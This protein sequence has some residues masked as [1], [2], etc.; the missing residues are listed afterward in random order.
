MKNDFSAH[1]RARVMLFLVSQCITLFGSTLVQMAVVWYATMNT[2]SGSWVAAFSVAAYLPQF[3]ISFLGG[4]WADR[5]DRKLLII[6]SDA[7]IAVVTLVMLLIMPSVGDEVQLMVSLLAMSVLRSMGSGIQTPAVNS[8]I[9]LL[10]PKDQLMRY[11]GI[12]SAMQSLVQ[13]A[14]PAAAGVIF[15]VSELRTTLMIDVI[16]AAVGIGLFLPIIIPGQSSRA[17]DCQR[18]PVL[19]DMR[20]SISYAAGHRVVGR[21]LLTYGGFVFLCVPAGFLAGLLV[22]R[23]FGDTYWYLTAVELVG[24]AGMVIG[25]AVI[26]AWGGFRL[27]S[28]TLFL[29][30]VSFGVFALGLGLVQNFYLYL[31]LMAF[32]GVSLTMV[33]TVITTLLQENTAEN[34][35]GRIF[36][37]QS[38]VY[39][40]FLPAGMMIF[41]PLADIIPLQWIMVFSALPLI[42]LG[43]LIRRSLRAYGL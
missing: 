8:A 42:V 27:R 34:M 24:F 26:G 15:S 41:G 17:D 14:A 7:S 35:R 21:L 23:V 38:T 6:L 5:Y 43:A 2:A 1:W 22:R 25:G 13:F 3:L 16:T 40:G 28:T 29:A 36:G 9:P 12:N 30:L 4:V 39:S 32:Y 31:T 33:Q 20:A 18:K 11:N 37:L 10:V 19:Q